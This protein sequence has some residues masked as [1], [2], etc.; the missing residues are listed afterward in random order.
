MILEIKDL[1]AKKKKKKDGYVTKLF[2]FD[3]SATIML[4]EGHG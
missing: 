1:T 3:N 2:S 4:T